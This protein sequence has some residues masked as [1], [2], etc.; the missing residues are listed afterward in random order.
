MY[1]ALILQRTWLIS[2]LFIS[3]AS[4]QGRDTTALGREDRFLQLSEQLENGVTAP[5]VLNEWSELALE[6]E[7]FGEWSA[8]KSKMNR[9]RI[10]AEMLTPPAR[11]LFTW[12]FDTT[13]WVGLSKL[14]YVSGIDDLQWRIAGH[15][16]RKWLDEL[17]TQRKLL[18]A[19]PALQELE[20]VANETLPVVRIL[21]GTLSLL[22]IAAVAQAIRRMRY[23]AR[24][25]QD[26]PIP[27]IITRLKEILHDGSEQQQYHMALSELELC[28]FHQSIEGAFKNKSLWNQLSEKQRLLL[29]F[30]KKEHSVADCAEYLQVSVG[31][32]YNERSKLRSLCELEEGDSLEQMF[33]SPFELVA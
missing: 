14:A 15:F 6:S 19:H 22:T 31:H 23:K 2:I 18:P 29:Y 11:F 12:D 1:N 16:Q 4:A 7:R 13:Q 17:S 5:D 32:L 20:P 25:Q 30:I 33:S 10:T 28:L 21:T 24:L 26:L 9:T 8:L 3:I 27:A